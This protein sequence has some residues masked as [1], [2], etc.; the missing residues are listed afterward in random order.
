MTRPQI[1]SL[2]NKQEYGDGCI[3]FSSD[4]S[5][6]FVLTGYIFT[7]ADRFQ[8]FHIR[9]AK[10]MSTPFITFVAYYRFAGIDLQW[11]WQIRHTLKFWIDIFQGFLY[12]HINAPNQNTIS[13][14]TRPPINVQPTYL[15][16][17]NKTL[18]VLLLIK[19]STTKL[20]L[21]HFLYKI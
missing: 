21:P 5:R 13:F 11:G 7:P 19:I 14:V 1:A 10:W 16:T 15:H 18:P 9:N 20:D 4:A 6:K 12:K 2:P 8:T 3:G 17:A